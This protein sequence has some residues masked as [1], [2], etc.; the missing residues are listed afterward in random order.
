M[1]IHPK[2]APVAAALAAALLAAVPAAASAARPGAAE[3]AV[4][5]A[6][7][8][9]GLAKPVAVADPHDRSGRLF[10]AEQDGL[11]RTIRGRRVARRPFLDLRRKVSRAY[12]RGLLGLAFHPDFR[13]NGFF[14]AG[15][16]DARGDVRISRFTARPG[17]NRVSVRTEKI[18]F[19]IAHREFT[20]ANGGH[21]VFGPDGYLYIGVG[22]GGGE[23]DPHGNA[24]NRTNLLGKILRVDVNT[25]APAGYA[26]PPGNP[27]D[28]ASG[29]AQEIWAYGF[30][31]PWRF[32]F[33]RRT[34]RMWIAD[35]GE[36]LREEIDTLAAGEGGRNFGWDCWEGEV[37]VIA[38][39]GGPYCQGLQAVPPVV[40]Y[41]IS[42]RRCAAVGGF[43]YRGRRYAR[44]LGGRY[45]YGDFCGGECWVLVRRAGGGYRNVKVGQHTRG[46]IN[47]FGEDDAG[48]L[49][50]VD[51]IRGRVYRV[52]AC[53]RARPRALNC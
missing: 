17:A 42:R 7:L 52:R 44:L 10:V 46:M 39:Q 33:D 34:G 29:F 38:Q 25:T 2:R 23:G 40:S 1:P 27:F 22:D 8:V 41:A 15:Y 6:P 11:V 36:H 47:S 16:T 3:I 53:R 24:Q 12:E 13:R 51:H 18:I 49:Y 5:M 43:V 32:S 19:D 20:N 26:I 48:E 14:Y 45:L 28:A 31:H 21:M 37:D 9:R 30:R 50:A 4:D 35:I